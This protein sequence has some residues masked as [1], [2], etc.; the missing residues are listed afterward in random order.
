M[1][2]QLTKLAA[3][4]GSNMAK[5]KSNSKSHAPAQTKPT[6][7]LDLHGFKT[8]DV[9]AA[10]DRFLVHSMKRGLSSVRIMPG[11]GTGAVRKAVMDYLKL[12]GYPFR[13]EKLSATKVNEGV[14]IVNLD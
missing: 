10:V 5:S 13:F 4:R 8:E 9:P 7:T 11:K 1:M 12:G 14:L 6:S 3:D 2:R